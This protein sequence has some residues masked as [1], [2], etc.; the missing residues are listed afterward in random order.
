LATIQRTYDQTIQALGAAPELGG[1]V[2]EGHSGRVAALAVDVAAD[3]GFSRDELVNLRTAALLHHLGQV[4]LDEPEDGRRPEPALVANA[5]ADILR[6]TALLAPAGEIIAA[7]V[8]PAPDRVQARPSTMAG[9]ILKVASSFDEIT[10]GHPGRTVLALD[11]LVSSPAYVYDAT[12]LAALER[13]LDE[14]GLLDV[15]R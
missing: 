6:G 12:V 13:V 9:Q 7:E 15:M 5:G 1:M 8:L 14:R 10:E 4:C 3:L 2:I 11:M